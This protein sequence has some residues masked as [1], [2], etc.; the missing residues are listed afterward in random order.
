MIKVKP[1]FVYEYHVWSLNVVVDQNTHKVSYV[2]EKRRPDVVNSVE[3][4]KWLLKP[5]TFLWGWVEAHHTVEPVPHGNTTVDVNREHC[6]TKQHVI[7]QDIVA[8]MQYF[9]QRG[10][11]VK[12]RSL[13]QILLEAGWKW[14]F[15]PTGPDNQG[16]L[17]YMLSPEHLRVWEDSAEHKLL[18][19]YA[20]ALQADEQF[21][22][23]S[24]EETPTSNNFEPPVPTVKQPVEH[25]SQVAQSLDKL[26]CSIDT[27]VQGMTALLKFQLE[28]RSGAPSNFVDSPEPHPHTDARDAV[29]V[30]KYQPDSGQTPDRLLELR[31]PVSQ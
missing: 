9:T 18:Q 20:E 24:Q 3:I 12:A 23:Q 28:G 21:R 10:E 13:E 29:D 25:T 15:E 8:A 22:N 14:T 16:V 6:V 1:P 31:S 27:L 26:Q 17:G 7:N 5:N 11:T 2:W 30:L 19:R 4:S